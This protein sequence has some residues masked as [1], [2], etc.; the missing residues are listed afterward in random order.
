MRKLIS[1]KLLLHDRATTA[2]SI[3]G[4]IAIV[5]LVGQQ[6][7]V[8]F[9][10]FTFMS[11]LVDHSGAD[12]WICTENTDNI[13]FTGTLPVR[14]VDRISGLADVQWVEP[15]V[16]G[17]GLF[18]RPDG[19]YQVVQIVGLPRPR[20]PLA[21]WRF[22]VGNLEALFDY[23]GITVDQLDLDT[24]GQ[25]EIGQIVEIASRRVKIAGVTRNIR[26]FGGGNLVF[27]NIRNAR[28]ITRLSA[29]RCNYI[30]VK[31]RE[32]SR[33]PAL[34]AE[35]KELLPR[36]EA[37]PT[38]ELARNTRLYYIA[39]TGIGGS[40]GFS[41]LIGALVGIVIITLTMYTAVLNRQKDFAVLRAIGARRQDILVIVL[42]QTL[43]VA[44]AGLFFGFLLLAIFLSG[45]RDQTIPTAVITWV[46]PAHAVLTVIF[47]FLGSFFAMRKAVRIEPAT[48]FR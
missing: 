27:T 42:Y 15:V 44:L 38:A 37:I 28:E 10:L 33:V 9:G 13:N 1:L 30:L 25:P 45:V 43:F 16:S 12:I 29:D 36:A 5:F 41:V 11:V 23:D 47:C 3:L 34:A 26:G 18:K 22:H 35:L 14:Y 40:F 7:S 39:N 4:V 21:P 17:G 32:E 6:Y 8:L 20:L 31:A 2:G 24:F 46:P 48:V 19:Q